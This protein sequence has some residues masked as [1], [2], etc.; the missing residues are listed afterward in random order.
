MTIALFSSYET[1]GPNIYDDLFV[2]GPSDLVTHDLRILDPNTGPWITWIWVGPN[3]NFSQIWVSL[4][5]PH[6]K[7]HLCRFAVLFL[8][9]QMQSCFS[10]VLFGSCTETHGS[11]PCCFLNKQSI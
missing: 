5:I 2:I 9:P 10:G 11:Q 4:P 7:V 3:I 6:D 8:F 1:I